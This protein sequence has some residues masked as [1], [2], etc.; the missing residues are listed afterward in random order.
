M[1]KECIAIDTNKK[2]YELQRK[3][4]DNLQRLHEAQ[5]ITGWQYGD[6]EDM[7]QMMKKIITPQEAQSAVQELAKVKA[8]LEALKN[9]K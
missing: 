7:V 2:V 6:K 3:G 8:E 9:K 5:N 4:L 1:A